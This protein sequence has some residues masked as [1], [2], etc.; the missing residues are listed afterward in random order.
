MRL[1]L[2]IGNTR[3]KWGRF[4]DGR[5]QEPGES[6]H[7]GG[8]FS[9]S[10]RF[11]DQID[12]VPDSVLAANVAGVAAGEAITAAIQKK[13]SLPVVFAAAEE[14]QDSLR[15]GYRDF[16]QLGVDRWLA[17]LAARRLH[18]LP[19]C[20]VDAGT[21]ITVDLVDAT[22]L[23]LGGLIAPGLALM[24]E[25]LYRDTGEIQ[26][27]AAPTVFPD[28]AMDHWPAR[29]TT[30]AVRLGGRAATVGMIAHSMQWLKNHHGSAKLVLT[31][32]SA[33]QLLPFLDESVDV[34]P[35]LVLEG[36]ALVEVQ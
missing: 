36:L 5:I 13:F 24:E 17:M 18:T 34:Q 16:Q 15:N 4:V 11:I 20:I 14:S 1:L 27:A 25:S 6:L 21:A 9:E 35:M 33:Q 28:D 7:R 3:I 26:I 19:L 32:G 10:L 22:G 30:A 23:H 2:D 8:A 31:G 29:D 12:H